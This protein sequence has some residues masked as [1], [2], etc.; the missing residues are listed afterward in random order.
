MNIPFLIGKEVLPKS[1][2]GG[3]SQEYAYGY[4]KIFPLQ[5]GT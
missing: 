5:V 2:N 4:C 1:V 3:V